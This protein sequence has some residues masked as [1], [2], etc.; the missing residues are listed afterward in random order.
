M[1]M[2]RF[3]SLV[4]VFRGVRSCVRVCLTSF[5]ND[6]NEIHITRITLWQRHSG[7]VRCPA[8]DRR[9][10]RT[11]GTQRM[12]HDAT[13]RRTGRV[14]ARAVYGSGIAL[15]IRGWGSSGGH[16]YRTCSSSVGVVSDGRP[17]FSC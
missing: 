13:G 6:N 8:N 17:F 15:F 12:R 11:Q 3:Y 1:I 16:F 10:S 7:V 14:R 9:D 4:G 5:R 2:I